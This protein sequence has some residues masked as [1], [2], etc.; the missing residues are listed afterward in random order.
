MKIA[1]ISDCHGRFSPP[2]LQPLPPA[3]VLVIAGDYCPNFTMRSHE[4]DA[5]MQINWLKTIFVP[6]LKT[7]PY[8]KIIVIAG[9]HDWCHYVGPTKAE[10]KALINSVGTYL[11]DEIFKYEN[12]VFYGSP[13][14]PWFYD[15]AFMF[16][17]W[18][19]ANGR[20]QARAI[21]AKIPHDP[22]DT[23][24]QGPIDVLITHGPPFRVLDLAP[25]DRNVGCPMLRDKVFQ[26]KPKLH[27]FGH[28]HCAYGTMEEHGVRFGN[29]ALC[30]EEY[31]PSQPIQVFEV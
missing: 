7:M 5:A 20:K 31:Q 16:N 24:Y 29:V 10:A 12:K 26:V 3:D 1:A 28:I 23:R 21:W 8:K 9:N 19:P 4:A 14:T 25:G 30:D 15:W 2:F 11:E 18:D 22:I 13:W 27:L 17:E 6:F